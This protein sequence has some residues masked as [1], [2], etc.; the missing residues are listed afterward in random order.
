MVE[1]RNQ[2]QS[3]NQE[4]K[5]KGGQFWKGFG[6]ICLSLFLAVLMVFVISL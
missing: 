3:E 4:S 6:L 5:K 2:Y 1:D